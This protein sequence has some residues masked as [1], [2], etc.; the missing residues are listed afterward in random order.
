MVNILSGKSLWHLLQIFV[1]S[2][3]VVISYP[4]DSTVLGV[5]QMLFIQYMKELLKK[6]DTIIG[7]LMADRQERQA[8]KEARQQE[9]RDA[10]LIEYAKAKNKQLPAGNIVNGREAGDRPV[11]SDGDLI[12]MNLN[13][14]EK[15]ILRDFYSR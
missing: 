14:T 2:D 8:E 3:S 1:I 11:R 13:S 4:Q 6:M 7:L 5:C 12:P 15:E 9:E 10:L